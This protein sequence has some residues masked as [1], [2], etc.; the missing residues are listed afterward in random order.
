VA[1][2]ATIQVTL[3]EFEQQCADLDARDYNP[4]QIACVLEKGEGAVRQA[5]RSAQ[6]KMEAPRS[7]AAEER[8]EARRTRYD[9]ESA[10]LNYYTEEIPQV[11]KAGEAVEPH[12]R[13]WWPFEG[14]EP[15][16]G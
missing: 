12:I 9:M 10:A 1:E 14:P 11:N 15:V 2:S 4:R 5:L 16:R 6:L 13:W 7:E 8:R 3:T